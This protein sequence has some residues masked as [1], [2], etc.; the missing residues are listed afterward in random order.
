MMGQA[1]AAFECTSLSKSF[2][3]RKVLDGLDLRVEPGQRIGLLG[4][5]GGQGDV[6]LTQTF[7][8]PAG[9]IR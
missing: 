8:V 9:V 1:T 3:G 6:T 7:V 4:G 2:G 5:E